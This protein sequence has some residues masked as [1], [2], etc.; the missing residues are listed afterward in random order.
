MKYEKRIAPGMEF[1]C[2]TFSLQ[3]RFEKVLDRLDAKGLDYGRCLLDETCVVVW[4]SAA[5]E[6]YYGLTLGSA[7]AAGVGHN[8][9]AGIGLVIAID[10]LEMFAEMDLLVAASALY[11]ESVHIE[12]FMSGRIS[13]ASR[14]EDRET[15]VVWEGEIYPKPSNAHD[16]FYAPWE[17]EAYWS[18]SLYMERHGGDEAEEIYDRLKAAVAG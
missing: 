17:V 4:S 14:I 7:P 12:Q 15:V 11:H 3:E 8:H 16:Y 6:E 2:N 9:D 13:E 18:Q 5:M 1:E 10:A